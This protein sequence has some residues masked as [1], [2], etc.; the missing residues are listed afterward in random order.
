MLPQNKLSNVIKFGMYFFMDIHKIYV[1]IANY[2]RLRQLLIEYTE[3]EYVSF[4]STMYLK[5]R[6]IACVTIC[7][8]N[9]TELK[10]NFL[11]LLI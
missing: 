6:C 10:K 2:S 7:F 4:I 1:K 5:K 8:Y 11:L 9:E 3:E